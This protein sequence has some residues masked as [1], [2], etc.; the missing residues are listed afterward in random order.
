MT[1]LVGNDRTLYEAC[2]AVAHVNRL[3]AL[4]GHESTVPE[5]VARV[6]LANVVLALLAIVTVRYQ[7]L[8]PGI[9]AAF[10]RSG[11]VWGGDWS[12]AGK[13]PMHFQYC[14]GY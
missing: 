7:A 10:K 5:I 2:D 9:V 11:F 1:V 14:S 12:G 6:F 8:M 3:A 13:D 4:A